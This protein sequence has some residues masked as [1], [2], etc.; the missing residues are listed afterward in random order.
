VTDAAPVSL[1]ANELLK[2]LGLLVDGPQLWSRPV[3][4]RS[5]GVFVVELAA[6]RPTHPSTSLRFAAG[7]IEYLH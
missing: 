7:W 5:P 6:P 2:G 4:S 1:S 3:N